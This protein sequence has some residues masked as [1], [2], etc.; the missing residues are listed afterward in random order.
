[1]PYNVATRHSERLATCFVHAEPDDTDGTTTKDFLKIGLRRI[2][3]VLALLASASLVQ[4]SSNVTLEWEPSPDTGVVGYFLFD[5]IVG[6]SHINSMDV[7]NQTK[8]TVTN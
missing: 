7:G 1:M 5:G 8:A 6:T 2:E 4:A 3:I